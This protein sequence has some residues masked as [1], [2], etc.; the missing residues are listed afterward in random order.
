MKLYEELAEQLTMQINEGYF[1]PGDKLPS[2]RQMSK[3]HKVS[4]STVQEA[5][6]LLESHYLV[7]VRLKSGYYVSSR[8][9]IP[10]LPDISRPY[11]KPVGVSR[12]EMVVQLLHSHEKNSNFALGKGTPRC[13]WTNAQTITQVDLFTKPQYSRYSA[14]L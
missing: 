1:Q 12:W 13:K 3:T 11:S 10:K 7:E 6:R 9:T 5:Y 2:I 4:I 8:N 14:D